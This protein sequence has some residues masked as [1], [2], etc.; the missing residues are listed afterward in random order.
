MLKVLHGIEG[1]HITLGL[2]F[3][4]FLVFVATPFLKHKLFGRARRGSAYLPH[5]RVTPEQMRE[6]RQLLQ[7]NKRREKAEARDSAPHAED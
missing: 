1:G 4:V 6:A 5:E 2:I 3:L 7:Q